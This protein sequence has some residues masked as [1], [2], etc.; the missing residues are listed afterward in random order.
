MHCIAYRRSQ[1]NGEVNSAMNEFDYIKINFNEGQIG[2]LNFCLAFLM[3]GVALEI[4]LSAF[5]SIIKKPRSIIVGLAAQFLLLPILTLIL[6]AI[7]KP[8]PSI[9]AGMLLI[10]ACPGG[11]VSSYAAYLAKANIPLSILL[12]MISSLT[13]VVTTPAIFKLFS[14]IVGSD[15]MSGFRISFLDMAFAMVKIVLLP[16]LLGMLFRHLFSKQTDK[17]LPFIKGL[18]FLIFVGFIIAAIASNIDNMA[19]YLHIV[20]F[21][22]IIHNTLGLILG[23]YIARWIQLDIPDARTVSIEAGIQNSGLALILIFNFFDGNGGMSLIAA[24]WSVWHLISALGIAKIWS[25]RD[26]QNQ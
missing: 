17:V 13:C 1:A 10:A 18:S 23:Y 9:M 26:R 7:L 12:S 5:K 22:V 16:L 3:F 15:V 2:L 21:I 8:S 25:W 20:F 11:N 6:I 24:W 14:F 19:K 4:D